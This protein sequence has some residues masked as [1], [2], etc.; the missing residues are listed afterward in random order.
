M[1]EQTQQTQSRG[2]KWKSCGNGCPPIWSPDRYIRE[3]KQVVVEIKIA[4]LRERKVFKPTYVPAG[5][6]PPNGGLAP[7]Y[8]AE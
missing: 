7:S 4:A 5:T 8:G 3:H 1:S 6:N 2:E